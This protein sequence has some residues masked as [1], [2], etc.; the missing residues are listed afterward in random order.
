MKSLNYFFLITILLCCSFKN[1]AQQNKI[2]VES[3]I[4]ALHENNNTKRKQLNF[5][6]ISKRKKGKFDLSTRF[7]VFRTKL[8]SLFRPSKFVS[9]I[10]ND[11]EQMSAKAQYRLNKYNARIGTIWFDSHGAYKK[12]YSLFKIGNSEYDFLTLKDT[13]VTKSIK[14]LIPFVDADT[15]VVIGSCY[16][17]A[18]YIRSSVDYKDTTRMNGDSLMIAL[19]ELL[20]HPVVYACESWVM[21]KPGLFLKRASVAGFPGRKLF[22]DICYR[23]AWEN[24]GKWNAYNAATDEFF[25]I[26]PITLDRYG[27][28][29]IRG[30]SY[31]NKKETRKKIMKN[32]GKLEPGLYK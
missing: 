3:V 14:E 4:P 13:S 32:L 24:M 7:N 11:G 29:M 18:T 25:A 8:K 17:G 5:F 10:A 23:P 22:R 26:N 21:T 16:G 2:E 30:S 12:G 31:N 28:S 27:R 19:G 20:Q 6:I 15:R 1:F 9:I